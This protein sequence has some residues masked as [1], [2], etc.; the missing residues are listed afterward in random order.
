MRVLV[1]L[2]VAYR[3]PSLNE[4]SLTSAGGLS[5]HTSA[6]MI[7]V[8]SNTH[9]V[10]VFAF[11][12]DSQSLICIEGHVERVGLQ[13]FGGPFRSL[14]DPVYLRSTGKKAATNGDPGVHLVKVDRRKYDIVI[15]LI[16]HNT[17]VPN[18]AFWNSEAPWSEAETKDTPAIFLTSIDISGTVYV[19]DVCESSVVFTTT[20]SNLRLGGTSPVS[21]HE[22]TTPL[23]THS[24]PVWLELDMC[25]SQI[26]KGEN[27][28]YPQYRCKDED[29]GCI[30][31][32][33]LSL[34]VFEDLA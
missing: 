1:S 10:L 17:N 24:R 29:S 9:K 12:L 19:W 33:N 16:A 3:P 27:S 31:T 20:C 4:N 11:A 26:T 28:V 2:P 13:D 5:I 6:R 34:G 23:L 30:F 32:R 15:G 18:V 14:L 25:G 22:W 21:D 8:S 7:A